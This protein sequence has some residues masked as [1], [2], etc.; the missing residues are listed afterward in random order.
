MSKGYFV[1]MAPVQIAADDVGL[2]AKKTTDESVTYPVLEKPS[3]EVVSFLVNVV[4]LAENAVNGG[5]QDKTFKPGSIGARLSPPRRCA[6][7]WTSTATR[8]SGS[9]STRKTPSRRSLRF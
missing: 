7:R 1:N 9:S 6:M 8:S 3:K 5:T 4:G 2:T